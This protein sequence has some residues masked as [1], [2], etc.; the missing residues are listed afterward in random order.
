MKRNILAFLA[1]LIIHLAMAVGLISAEI[2]TPHPNFDVKEPAAA[3]SL[4]FVSMAKPEPPAPEP[5]APEPPA[6]EPPA[7]KPAVVKQPTVAKPVAKKPVVKK[8]TPKKAATKRPVV[9]KAVQQKALP[10]AQVTPKPAPAVAAQ[11]APSAPKSYDKTTFFRDLIRQ[12]DRNK[13]YPARAKELRQTGTARI[14]FTLT[15][16]GAINHVRI[17]KSSGYAALDN[18]A[19][20]AVASITHYKAPPDNH[21]I[22]ITLPINFKLTR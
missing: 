15:G 16:R 5:P 6:P 12:I 3:V 20:Q 11:S 2:E 9:K 22:Q 13:H 4:A 17:A 7:P 18:A 21:T 10:K 19:K 14:A 1:A 8:P